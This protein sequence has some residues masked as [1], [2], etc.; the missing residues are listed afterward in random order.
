[1]TPISRGL[2]E[3]GLSTPYFFARCKCDTGYGVLYYIPLGLSV[4][5]M[6]VSAID[7]CLSP[8]LAGNL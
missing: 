8:E 4:G 6:L 3:F 1:M 2:E 5:A 7:A